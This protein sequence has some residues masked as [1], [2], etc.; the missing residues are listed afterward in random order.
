MTPPTPRSRSRRLSNDRLDTGEK[1]L[2]HDEPIRLGGVQ[3]D[4]Q[5]VVMGSIPPVTSQVSEAGGGTSITG[6]SAGEACGPDGA[7]TAGCLVVEPASL[8]PWISCPPRSGVLHAEATRRIMTPAIEGHLGCIASPTNSLY[9]GREDRGQLALDGFRH[10]HRHR[11]PRKDYRTAAAPRKTAPAPNG[12][13]SSVSEP[14]SKA[15][16]APASWPTI[17]TTERSDER[18][19]ARYR[20]GYRHRQRADAAGPLCLRVS[21]VQRLL[22]PE[23]VSSRDRTL[24]LFPPPRPLSPDAAASF[25]HQ[26]GVSLLKSRSWPVQSK[27]GGQNGAAAGAPPLRGTD[28]PAAAGALGAGL[29]GWTPAALPYRRLRSPASPEP[30][31]G[32]PR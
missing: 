7:K 24:R 14:V 4:E 25:A 5:F 17:S 10:R 15:M 26:C 27:P 1:R 21:L 30:R 20:H 3:V 32:A 13:R 29:A 18:C 31:Q 2:R 22:L 9:I 12:N 6:T 8:W 23:P 28:P 11:L 19:G 16:L